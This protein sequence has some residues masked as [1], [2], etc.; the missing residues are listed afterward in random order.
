M[1]RF[2]QEVEGLLEGESPTLYRHLIKNFDSSGHGKQSLS[3]NRIILHCLQEMFVG[4]FACKCRNGMIS[5]SPSPLPKSHPSALNMPFTCFSSWAILVYPPCHFPNKISAWN[6]DW[7]LQVWHSC[8]DAG[9]VPME[10]LC[11]IW[12]QC[13][14][15]CS[16]YDTLKYFVTSWLIVLKHQ[17]LACKNVSLHAMTK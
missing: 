5:S 13:F 9:A 8:V 11:F 6:T 16:L 4:M 1:N 12:D 7:M 14:I 15:G 3:H 17:L 2:T 10:V